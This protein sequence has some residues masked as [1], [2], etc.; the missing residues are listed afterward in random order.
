MTIFSSKAYSGVSGYLPILILSGGL[1]SAGQI[2]SICLL[3]RRD[4]KTL[5]LPKAATAILG[6]IFY[7][8]GASLLG[9]KGVVFGNVAF[10]AIYTLW[11]SAIIFKANY[12]RPFQPP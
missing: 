2:L 1:F 10:S 9:L 5:L 7:F 3:S 11:L 12:K 8:I 6:I 4:T